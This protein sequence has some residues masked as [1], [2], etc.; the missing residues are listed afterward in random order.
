MGKQREIQQIDDQTILT[1]ELDGKKALQ[2]F[3]DDLMRLGI[4]DQADYV[5]KAVD[6]EELQKVNT[7]IFSMIG[8]L[9]SF[10][11]WASQNPTDF[12]KLFQHSINHSTNSINVNQNGQGGLTII[13]GIPESNLDDSVLDVQGKIIDGEG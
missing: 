13:T 11:I 4:R 3:N 9:P 8:G 6:R 10:A 5:F 2:Q 12:Y 1:V 7:A